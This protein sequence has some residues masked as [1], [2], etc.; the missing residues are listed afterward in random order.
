MHLENARAFHP[1]SKRHSTRPRDRKSID[2]EF[3]WDL[4]PLYP[5]E[6]RWRGAKEALKRKLSDIET[7]RGTLNA[8]AGR[9]FDCLQLASDLYREFARLYVYASMLHDEDTRISR[10]LAMQ[11]E[12]SQI[13]S[14]LNARG[15]FIEPEILK[16]DPDLLREFLT[17][18]P[19]LKIYR[20]YLDD[21]QRRRPH[22]RTEG[23]ERIIA[24]AGLMAEGAADIHGIFANAEFDYPTV[25]LSTK[26]KIRLDQA[27]F[28]LYRASR[29]RSDRKK[30]FDAFFGQLNEYRRTFG[31]QLNA[32]VRKNLF[33]TRAR[34]YESPLQNALD[35]NNIPVEVYHNLTDNV[36]RHLGTFH[37]YLALRKRLL[38]VPSLHYYDLYAPLLKHVDLE[39]SYNDACRIILEAF[40]PLGPEYVDV[41]R[42]AFHERWIDVYPTTAKRSG[43]YSNGAAYDVHP[44]I[45]L[46]YNGKFDD[47]STLAHEL[48]H[49]MHSY[50][51]NA[52][53]PYA[54]SQYAIFVAE[55]ASTFNE[56]LLMEHMLHM[57]NDDQ[58]R[59]SLLGN[60][61]ENIKGTVFRQTQF[62][63]FELRIHEMVQ[64]GEALTG[65]NL[66]ALYLELTRKYYGHSSHICLVDDVIQAEWMYISHFYY[67]FYVYQYATAFTASAALSEEVLAGNGAAR[68]RYLEFLGA[69]SS[70]YPIT[71]LRNAGVD[72]TTSKPFELTMQKMNR[73]MDEMEKILRKRR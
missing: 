71:L 60:L 51:S 34:N 10:T 9:L 17:I 50:Y 47:L 35:A 54:T 69:G 7:F 30:V 62:A 12:M 67:N 36:N 2:V 6:E 25:V 43:A 66:N 52:K 5:N 13:G 44:Y 1:G 29:N 31:T 20:H 16:I 18:E 4:S 26:K 38:K 59:L 45:L 24:D 70:D 46:N 22:T 8:S 53:Q 23:E 41:V 68:E 72:M 3:T 37:R 28:T 42:R 33:Y 73:V 63:E 19:R 11:Q 64:Q 56:A 48:G 58:A 21:I 40:L 14:D 65:D 39:Y 55:V 27:N 49:T 15:A 61:L 57:I 32:E